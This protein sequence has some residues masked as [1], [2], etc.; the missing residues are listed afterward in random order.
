MLKN[1]IFRALALR[2]SLGDVATLP[3]RFSLLDLGRKCT[4]SLVN[5]ICYFC[6]W[7]Y[8]SDTTGD[9]G[10]PLSFP[11]GS[12]GFEDVYGQKNTYFVDKSKYLWELENQPARAFLS[13]RPRRMGKTLFKNMLASYVDKSNSRWEEQFRPL[14][15][16]RFKEQS[17]WRTSSLVL[18]LTLAGLKTESYSEFEF[19]LNEYLN[20]RLETFLERYP[21]VS[22]RIVPEDAIASLQNLLNEL[23]TKKEKV[24]RQISRC[25]AS[26]FMG[27]W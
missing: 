7:Y 3:G 10:T 14:E 11:Y 5:R 13:C 17:K 16:Y 12:S 19:S 24:F 27:W 21:D 6:W 18:D 23:Q 9:A 1:K 15:I 25:F 20:G 4:L 26:I 2:C 22:F 8:I